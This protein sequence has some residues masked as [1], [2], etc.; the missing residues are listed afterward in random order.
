MYLTWFLPS[1]P[2]DATKLA[3]A[4]NAVK[5]LE[6]NVKNTAATEPASVAGQAAT[7]ALGAT[8]TIGVA[9]EKPGVCLGAGD[10]DSAPAESL[11]RDRDHVHLGRHGLDERR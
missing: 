7:K 3:I 6:T 2:S 8:K 9:A 5:T 11:Q 10:L 4:N 1:A